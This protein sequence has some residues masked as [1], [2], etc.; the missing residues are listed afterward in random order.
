MYSNN[1][2][3][4]LKVVFGVI[5]TGLGIG[6][7][8]SYYSSFKNTQVNEVLLPLTID[9][10]ELDEGSLDFYL[11]NNIPI[12]IYR[13]TPDEISYLKKYNYLV[14]DKLSDKQIKVK[15]LGKTFDRIVSKSNAPW[16]S[17]KTR[18]IKE[19]VFVFIMKS[20][21]RGCTIVRTLYQNSTRRGIP[22]SGFK[23]Y[24]VDP[25]TQ[26]V[27]DLS[28]RILI[29]HNYLTHLLIPN[30]RYIDDETIELIPNE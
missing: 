3:Y 15:W 24:F 29:N 6:L 4:I 25:C 18:S 23:N 28:G 26:Q 2:Q 8:L 5:L 1:T 21:I 30:H 22:I 19:D 12:G 20:P 17:N 7:L 27:F 14:R 13:R 10:S 16:K 9:I 11:W